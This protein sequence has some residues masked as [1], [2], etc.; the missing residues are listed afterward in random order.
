MQSVVKKKRI[1]IMH[2]GLIYPLGISGPHTVPYWENLDMINKLVMGNYKVY[3]VLNDGTRVL[4]D[5]TNYDKENG[6]PNN[7][8]MQVTYETYKSIA[9]RRRDK[10]NKTKK[11]EVIDDKTDI[12][13]LLKRSTEQPPRGKTMDLVS[14]NKVIIDKPE[15]KEDK[16]KHKRPQ[17]DAV[18]DK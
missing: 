1:V 18:D 7:P 3:E 2:K 10:D 15:E 11:I 17:I 16:K 6:D 5:Y 14:P 13:K 12:Q 4:L 8:S 9:T